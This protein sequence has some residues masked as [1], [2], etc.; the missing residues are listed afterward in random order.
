MMPAKSHSA[1]EHFM[2]LAT[3]SSSNFTPLE[4]RAGRIRSRG[5]FSLHCT[6]STD[7]AAVVFAYSLSIAFHLSQFFATLI[8]VLLFF[9]SFPLPISFFGLPTGLFVWHLVLRPGFYVA[10]AF[11]LSVAIAAL[12]FMY[13]I[14]SSP[15]ISTVPISSS[16]SSM[17]ENVAVLVAICV[18]TATSA[19]STSELLFV[20]SLFLVDEAKHFALS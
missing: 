19:V 5:G 6:L 10:D 17:K 3:S 8:H 1:R 16:E 4:Q 20:L 2:V 18:R 12:L 14:R 13:S 15:S 11:I 9:N 7:I